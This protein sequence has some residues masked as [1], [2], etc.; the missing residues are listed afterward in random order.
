MKAMKKENS[1]M[2]AKRN[3]EKPSKL[4]GMANMKLKAE[5]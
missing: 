5:N 1:L 2:K 3:G 4:A